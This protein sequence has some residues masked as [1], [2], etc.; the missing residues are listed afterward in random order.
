MACAPSA[1]S[2]MPSAGTKSPAASSTTSPGNDVLDRGW[3]GAAVAAHRRVHGDRALQSL[4]RV[5][6]VVLLDHLQPDRHGQNRKNDDAARPVAGYA[7]DHGR[8]DEN[9]D[10]RIDQPL[11]NLAQ[12]CRWRAGVAITL[13]PPS[14]RRRAASSALSPAGV[15][16]VAPARRPCC[17]TRTAC[18]DGSALEGCTGPLANIRARIR[19]PRVSRRAWPSPARSPWPYPSARHICR[20]TRRSPC[21]CPSCRRRR[22]P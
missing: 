1:S 17:R 16:Q 9:G 6:R 7:R 2:T 19:R 22:S 13:G 14:R 11:H 12:A 10:Q 15:A 18:A 3:H 8:D 21:P 5:F 20:A 4:D